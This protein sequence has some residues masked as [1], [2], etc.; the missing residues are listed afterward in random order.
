MTNILATLAI[1][2]LTLLCV[3]CG[4]KVEEAKYSALTKD[5]PFEVREY[6]AH[7]LAVVVVEGSREE[8]GNRAFRPLF[9]YISGANRQQQKIADGELPSQTAPSEKIEMTAPVS[10]VAEEQKWAVSFMMPAK[11]SLETLPTPTDK[12]IEIRAVPARHMA[13][14][15]YSGGWSEESYLKHAK[16][17]KEWIQTQ[18]LTISGAAVWAR[19]NPPF[20]PSFM[21]RNEV[22]I[23]VS[24]M[25]QKR[26]DN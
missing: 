20:T 16:R 22:L 11:Y 15:R 6:A 21:R 8:A 5:K 4:Q 17:L 25:P 2:G 7:I 19:Y 1:A 3:A 26:E 10:Q 23:P 18:K 9:R 13:A 12:N 14:I 24:V